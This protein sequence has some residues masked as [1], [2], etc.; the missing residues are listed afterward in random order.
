MGPETVKVYEKDSSRL[1]YSFNDR[2][3]HVSLSNTG[4]KVKDSEIDYA[5]RKIMKVNPAKI[6]GR[7]SP[8]GVH[9]LHYSPSNQHEQYPVSGILQ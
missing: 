6:T 2:V 5:I 4:R 3:K 9:H 1:I 7:I 8:N